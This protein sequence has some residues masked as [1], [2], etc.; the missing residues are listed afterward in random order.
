MEWKTV[1]LA[2]AGLFVIYLAGSALLRPLKWLFRVASW[3]LAG[4]ILLV[5][6]N[7]VF[8]RMGFHIAINP[9]TVLT[10]GVLQVPGVLL[11]VLIN[12]L[13]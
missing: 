9:V 10:A 11:L 12:Y 1:F 2:M 5:V 3:A 13:L 7:A 4:V 8:G 6:I